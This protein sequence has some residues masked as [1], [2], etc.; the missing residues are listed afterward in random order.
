[1][2]TMRMLLII[3]LVASVATACGNAAAQP[4]TPGVV[5]M[6][7]VPQPSATPYP[8]LSSSVRLV[9]EFSLNRLHHDGRRFSWSPDGEAL[10]FL[11]AEEAVCNEYNSLWIAQAPSFLPRRLAE[12]PARSVS[13]SLTGEFVAFVAGRQPDC[14]PETVWVVR[15]GGA[16]P[17][18]LLP[19]ERAVR[20]VSSMKFLGPWLDDGT[21]VFMDSCGTGCR[22]LVPIDVVTGEIQELCG[23]S[24]ENPLFLGMNYHWSP[25]LDSFVVTEGG[26]IPRIR[27]VQLSDR[28]DCREQDLPYPGEFHAWSPYGEAFLFS[29]WQWELGQGDPSPVIAQVPS[30][31]IWDTP[32]RKARRIVS[33]G[34][35]E[36]AWS[37]DG[38]RL[39]FFLLGNPRYESQ[40]IIGSDLVP[41]APF[42]LF[43]VILDVQT[44]EVVAFVP[45][46]EEIHF[47][48]YYTEV[49]RWFD[50]RRP[51]WSSDGKRLVYWGPGDELWV[52]KWDGTDQQRLT[53]GLEVIDVA[54][55]PKGNR[56]AIASYDHLWILEVIPK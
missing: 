53:N 1:M 15:A 29:H 22:T 56:L 44:E 43:L 46:R 9:A 35:Y 23:S 26:G 3:I 4:T 51:V 49:R 25:S 5:V 52:M 39:A 41:G 27:L 24:E 42:P 32:Q 31:Y 30:L 16:D 21:L 36:G 38:E 13:W 8:V 17:R 10:V 33:A 12:Q 11:P 18:D 7:G 20:S 47:T 19:G 48:D 2:K 50:Q 40:R 45:I 14:Y 54:W 28:N 55:S 6:T 37:P 34:G